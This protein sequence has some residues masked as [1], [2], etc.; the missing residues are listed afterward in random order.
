MQITNFSYQGCDCMLFHFNVY[1]GKIIFNMNSNYFSG[2]HLEKKTLR[3]DAFF[4]IIFRNAVHRN[5]N[6]LP[7]RRGSMTPYTPYFGD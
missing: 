5:L 1:S 3:V 7:I 2:C 6:G 4:F